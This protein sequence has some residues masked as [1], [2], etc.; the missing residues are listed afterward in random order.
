[1]KSVCRIPNSHD[2]D[3]IAEAYFP[4]GKC[5]GLV[6]R[7]VNR[8]DGIIAVFTGFTCVKVRRILFMQSES[9]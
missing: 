9:Y 2:H 4:I 1:M 5:L 3:I 6:H 8:R 7:I